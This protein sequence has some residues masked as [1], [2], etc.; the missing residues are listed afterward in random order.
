MHEELQK[1]L[2]QCFPPRAPRSSPTTPSYIKWIE[3]RPSLCS[4]GGRRFLLFNSPSRSDP[5]HCSFHSPPLHKLRRAEAHSMEHRNVWLMCRSILLQGWSCFRSDLCWTTTTTMGTP[6]RGRSNLLTGLTLWMYRESDP[7]MLS[8]VVTKV[9]QETVNLRAKAT[10]AFAVSVLSF[11]CRRSRSAL[12]DCFYFQ[13]SFRLGCFFTTPHSVQHHPRHTW[14]LSR[15]CLGFITAGATASS[16]SR[17]N[18]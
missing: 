12:Y 4:I 3:A 15:G 14:T 16:E 17:K 5:Q 18:R 8:C 11:G 7:S 9:N 10:I 13:V 6:K 1:T 2:E